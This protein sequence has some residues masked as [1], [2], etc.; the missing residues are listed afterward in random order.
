MRWNPWA[1]AE[2]YVKPDPLIKPAEEE[3]A[4]DVKPEGST[5]AASGATKNKIAD[6]SSGARPKEEEKKAGTK[7]DED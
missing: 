2:V 1:G 4:A 3:K 6:A 5:A 7:K